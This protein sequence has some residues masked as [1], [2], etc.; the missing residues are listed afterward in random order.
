MTPKRG[1]CAVDLRTGRVGEV[2]DQLGRFVQLRPLRGGVEWDCPRDQLREATAAER[3]RAD[4][5]E[6]NRRTRLF[7]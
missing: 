2:M 6:V 1:A 3:L 5:A 7:R 4:L